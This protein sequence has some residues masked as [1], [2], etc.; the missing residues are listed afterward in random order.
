MYIYISAK[1]IVS[2]NLGGNL[3][4]ILNSSKK[5]ENVHGNILKLKDPFKSNLIMTHITNLLASLVHPKFT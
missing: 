3:S 4:G 1:C 5:L 2:L